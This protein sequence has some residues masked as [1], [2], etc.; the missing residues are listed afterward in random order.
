MQ[1]YKVRCHDCDPEIT[2]HEN[3]KWVRWGDVERLRAELAECRSKPQDLHLHANG[4]SIDC[5][6][7][8]HYLPPLSFAGD[9]ACELVSS[10][11]VCINGDAY[12][13]ADPV[14]LYETGEA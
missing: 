13:P 2:P 14:R 10:V 12:V 5:R 6:T 11:I 8:A 3:G 7:C 4:D 9:P 1:R